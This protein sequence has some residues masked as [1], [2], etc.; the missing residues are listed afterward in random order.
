VELFSLRKIRRI[1]PQHR[2]PGPPAPAHGS[3]NFIK[4]R[5]LASG[6]R[7]RL[8]QANWYLSFQSWTFIANPTAEAAGSGRGWRRLVLTEARHGRARWLAWV[9]VFSSYGGRFSM[10]FAPTGSQRRGERVYANLNRQ[11]SPAT[12]RR[13]GRCLSTLRTTSGE[14][15]APRTCAKASLSS[16]LASRPTNCSNRRWKTRIWWLPRVRRVLYLRPKIHTIC[17]AIYR[18]F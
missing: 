2:G 1:C 5:S 6:S 18:G 10:R 15:S 3:T 14:A 12:V 13:L 17:G 7:L 16:L 4:R 9:R 8:N 11:R